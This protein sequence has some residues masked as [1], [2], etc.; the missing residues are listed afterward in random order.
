MKT[1]EI[2]DLAIKM[3]IE[4]DLRGSNEVEKF[5]NRKRRNMRP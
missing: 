5:L 1:Q 4:A 3:G 2:F